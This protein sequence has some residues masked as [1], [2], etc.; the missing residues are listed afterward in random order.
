MVKVKILG[1]VVTQ[2]YGT[3]KTGD[4][5][6]TS[7]DFARHLVND[8]NAAEYLKVEAKQELIS[9]PAKPNSKR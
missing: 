3:L 2:Q 9:K 7:E 6:A 4:I 8:C 5:L 1:S